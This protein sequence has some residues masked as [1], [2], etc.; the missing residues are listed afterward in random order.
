M[1][2]I[3]GHYDVSVRK[4]LRALSWAPSSHYYRSKRSDRTVLRR[5]MR[6]LAAARPRYGY[7]R[8]HILLR[9]EGWTLNLKTTYRLYKEERLVLR[10]RREKRKYAESW[11]IGGG[12]STRCDRTPR[13]PIECRSRIWMSCWRLRRRG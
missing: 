6:E 8:I 3:V 1:T 10:I 11:R 13:Y 2:R 9:R 7:R 12:T 4:A 5:R